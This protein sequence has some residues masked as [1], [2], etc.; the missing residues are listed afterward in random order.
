MRY[1]VFSLTSLERNSASFFFMFRC[2]QSN[3]MNFFWIKHSKSFANLND[4][5]IKS[6]EKCFC[7]ASLLLLTFLHLKSKNILDGENYNTYE[8]LLND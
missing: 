1:F 5:S 7:V 8:N 4:L 2:S 3:A 6:N